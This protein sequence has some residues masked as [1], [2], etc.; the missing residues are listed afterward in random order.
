MRK[1][2]EREEVYRGHFDECLRHLS[3][4]MKLHHPRGA[5]GSQ[6]AKKPIGDFCGVSEMTT[7]RWIYGH[8]QGPSG[9]TRIKMMC[10]LEMVGYR[11]IEITKMGQGKKGLLELIGYGL[12]SIDE[13]VTLLDY[14][15][16]QAI[17]RILLQE[18][19]SATSDRS[20]AMLNLWIQRKAELEEK[21]AKAFVEYG[22]PI[23]TMLRAEVKQLEE[24]TIS[25]HQPRKKGKT[26]RH[27]VISLME[28]LLELLNGESFEKA[29]LGELVEFQHSA[30]TV[31][32]LSSK[33]SGLSARLMKEGLG[34][35]V[36]KEPENGN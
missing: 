24:K 8:N 6:E 19:N 7:A 28:V 27:A 10:F 36:E 12:L 14:Q 13:A 11:V 26:S 3:R 1:E 5:R 18:E 16:P 34:K 31:L 35:E 29:P 23:A 20:Q 21:K 2:N 30:D 4:D 15:K 33:L 17:Y 25:N 9:L 22:T 32:S